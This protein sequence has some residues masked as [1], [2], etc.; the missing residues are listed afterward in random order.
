M[1]VFNLACDSQHV[2]EGWFASAEDFDSQS[3]REL[4]RCPVCDSARI[5]RRPSAPRLNLGAAEAAVPHAPDHEKSQKAWLQAM[6]W[7]VD[8]TDD[9]GE[10]F[11]EEARRIHHREAPERGIRGTATS[12]QAR[13]L[14]EEGIEMLRLPLPAVVKEPLQ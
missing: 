7:L 1:I 4:V 10:H 6:R 5:E 11:P 12:E 2:F 8:S 13:E 3:A 14:A 9:V